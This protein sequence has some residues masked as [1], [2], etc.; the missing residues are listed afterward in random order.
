MHHVIEHWEKTIDT[1]LTHT[2]RVKLL[3]NLLEPYDRENKLMDGRMD[4]W[5]ERLIDRSIERL[6][7]GPGAQ[8]ARRQCK[9]QR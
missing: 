2:T 1:V 3:V 4:E 8:R 5:S 7:A 9:L 6:L